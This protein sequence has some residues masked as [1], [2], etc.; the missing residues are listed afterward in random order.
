[1]DDESEGGGSRRIP[2]M[3]VPV[4]TPGVPQDGIVW[5]QWAAAAAG[6]RAVSCADAGILCWVGFGA[7]FGAATCP[8][9]DPGR[10]FGDLAAGL[11]RRAAAGLAT[12][13][14]DGGYWPGRH[15]A[16][17]AARSAQPVLD[18]LAGFLRAGAWPGFAV[19]GAPP[20]T[21]R[22]AQPFRGGGRGDR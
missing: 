20:G 2:P 14:A 22:P 7:D 10:G 16:A 15:E 11:R 4:P 19:P 13:L 9:E 1:M 21:G 5:T 3:P 18:A 12:R 8:D 6:A 17:L